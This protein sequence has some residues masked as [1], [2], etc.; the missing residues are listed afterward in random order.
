[1]DNAV[2]TDRRPVAHHYADPFHHRG[3][4][5]RAARSVL[6]GEVHRHRVPTLRWLCRTRVG[7]RLVRRGVR[8]DERL[9]PWPRSANGRGGGADAV[10]AVAE[11]D[12][13]QWKPLL[14]TTTRDD[15]HAAGYSYLVRRLERH[16]GHKPFSI[17][18]P[19][20]DAVTQDQYDA[21]EAAGITHVLTM[22]WMFY[23]GPG[24]SLEQKIDGMRR[25]LEEHHSAG[26]DDGAR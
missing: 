19:L 22:P 6:C 16:L 17:L 20:T 14:D 11:L 13:I 26:V 2:G 7:C 1:M 23:F 3:L 18:A 4:H 10:V 24:A 12:R 5:C 25:F 15:T 9:L 8:I 21:A